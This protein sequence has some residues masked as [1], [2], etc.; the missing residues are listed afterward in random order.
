MM[1]GDGVLVRQARVRAEPVHGRGR[2]TGVRPTGAP[3][4]SSTATSCEGWFVEDFSLAEIK[5][6]GAAE[7][8][9][10]V[11]PNERGERRAPPG[12]H[13]RRAPAPPRRSPGTR[14]GR[15]GS[16]PSSSAPRTSGTSAS[17]SRRRSLTSLRDHGLDRRDSGVHLQSFEIANLAG[18]RERTDVNLVQLVATAGAPEDCR[19]AGDPTT[20]DDLG[21][22]RPGCGRL[23]T[24]ADAVGIAKD[25]LLPP[26]ARAVPRRRPAISWT[27]RTSKGCACCLHSARRELLPVGRLPDRHRPARP[28]RRGRRDRAV[29]D[30]GVDG[31]FTDTPEVTLYA[32]RQWL[33]L[34]EAPRASSPQ[35]DRQLRRGAQNSRAR[36]SNSR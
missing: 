20:Y 4:S 30:L 5:T 34:Q 18:S 16:T 26:E 27:R 10:L 24:Y 36:N 21:D 19:A 13:F 12:R 14:E 3:A 1:T 15:S 8:F 6:C 9:P 31:V 7:R 11:R 17:R 35:P 29:F 2:P 32:R 23:A 28:R 33:G 25:R 22:L